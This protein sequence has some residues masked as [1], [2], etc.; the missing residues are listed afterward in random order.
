MYGFTLVRL[1]R[2]T[3]VLKVDAVLRCSPRAS[4]KPSKKRINWALATFAASEWSQGGY[5]RGIYIGAGGSVGCG[6]KGPILHWT[7]PV[8]L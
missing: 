5:G 4:K 1:Y 6:G 3:T 8:N 2:H 7:A